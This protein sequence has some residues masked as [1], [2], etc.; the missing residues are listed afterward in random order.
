MLLYNINGISKK[1][2]YIL[3]THA[4]MHACRHARTHA[5]AHTHTHTH[6]HACTHQNAHQHT[7]TIHNI[8]SSMLS[9]GYTLKLYTQCSEF[10]SNFLYTL[11]VAVCAPSCVRGTCTAPGVCRCPSGWTGRICET[12]K[13]SAII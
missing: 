13:W 6:T 5:H 12:R 4:R 8:S 10:F 2:P 9:M 1:K 3:D 7:C 11:H